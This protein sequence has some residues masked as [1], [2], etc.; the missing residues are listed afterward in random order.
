MIIKEKYINAYANK[1]SF[2]PTLVATNAMYSH[3]AISAK[4]G[5]AAL[6]C[7][8]KEMFEYRERQGQEKTQMRTD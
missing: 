3:V 2:T 4:I 1:V 8:V 5:H 7:I 6:T